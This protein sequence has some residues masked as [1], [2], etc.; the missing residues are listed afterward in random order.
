MLVHL[1]NL[2]LRARNG[3]AIVALRWTPALYLRRRHRAL[4]LHGRIRAHLAKGGCVL[5]TNSIEFSFHRDPEQFRCRPN[6][7]YMRRGNQW[8]LISHWVIRFC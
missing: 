8:V 5:V 1:L 4:A 7:V 2:A 3:W 6:G